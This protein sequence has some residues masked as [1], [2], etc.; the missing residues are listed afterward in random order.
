[1]SEPPEKECMLVECVPFTSLETRCVDSLTMTKIII[2]RT[3]D[4]ITNS[5]VKS[6]LHRLVLWKANEYN[7]VNISGDLSFQE[8]ASNT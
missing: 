2:Q 7:H 3:D 5:C 4:A 1:M 8:T 6:P